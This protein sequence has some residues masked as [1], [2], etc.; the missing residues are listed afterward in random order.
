[1][2][3]GDS[4][5]KPLHPSSHS[6]RPSLKRCRSSIDSVPS[7][8]PVTGSHD[9]ISNCP[10]RFQELTMMCT[11]MVPKE[12]YQVKRFIEGLP[13][14]IQGSVMTTEPTRLQD[15]VRIANNMM[16]KKL[17]GYDVRNAENKRRLDANRRDDHGQQPPFKRQNTGGQNVAR[18]YTAGNNETGGYVGTLPYYNRCKLHHEG[19]CIVKYSNYKRVGHKTRD[20]RSTI[21]ATTQGTLRPNQR[22]NTCFECRAPRHYCKDCSKIK[23]QNRRNKARIPEAR[24]KTYVLGGCDANLGSNTVMGTSLLN[25][26][27]AY[28]FFNSGADRSFVS[29]TLSTLLDITPSAL[30]VSYA[31]KL[32]DKRTLKTSIVLRGCTLGLL[33]RPF[34]IDLIPIDLGSFDVIIGMDW[35]TKNHAVIVYDEKIVRIPYG[36]EIMIVT[37]KENEDKSKEKQLEDV[38]TVHNFLEVFLEDLPG[39]PPIR[40]GAPVL[41]VKKKDGSLQMCIDYHELNKL[42]VK[43]QYPLPKI[44]DLFDQL[45]GSSVYL[46]IDLRSGYHQLRDHDDDILKTEFRT[47]C[48]HYEFQVMPFGLTNAPAVFMDLMN[49]IHEENYMMHDLEL[50]VVVFALK[51]WRHYLYDTRKMECSGRRIKSKGKI[52]AATSLSLGSDNWLNL[53]V[54][55]LNVQTEARIM[56][57]KTWVE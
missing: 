15:V 35:L 21:A 47:R 55:I 50:G 46:K 42:A 1:S 53:P 13:D 3:S 52:Q 4:S 17:K 18:A 41:F 19:H 25:D 54:Q 12:E 49:R 2:S 32:A 44:N 27:H 16:D 37:V 40:Q 56:E 57:L 6:V 51:I 26:H 10:K 31:V 43:N 7:S 48:G 8:T 33:R 23:N 45:Q 20:Y 34:N 28:M 30:D 39:L 29:N 24:G 14:N 22:I 9:H 38:P 36:N 5:E 11:K